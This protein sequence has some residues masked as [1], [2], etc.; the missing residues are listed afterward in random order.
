MDQKFPHLWSE[1]RTPRAGLLLPSTCID[2]KRQPFSSYQI[3][4]RRETALFISSHVP[5]DAASRPTSSHRIF[6]RQKPAYFIPSHVWTPQAGLH[7]PITCMDAVI[8]TTSFHHMYGCRKPALFIPSFQ[9][10]SPACPFH[11]MYAAS[12][13]YCTLGTVLSPKAGPERT[14]LYQV[15]SINEFTVFFLSLNLMMIPRKSVSATMINP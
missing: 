9:C 14:K 6:G 1:F 8:W 7:H 5:Y 15:H 2:A 13:M 4:G 10:K 3:Y 11:P 12:C